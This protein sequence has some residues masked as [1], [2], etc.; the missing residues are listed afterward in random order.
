MEAEAHRM[1]KKF[2]SLGNTSSI[3]TSIPLEWR[4]FFTVLL[5]SPDNCSWATQLL[6]RKLTSYLIICESNCS[7]LVIPPSC[8]DY[9]LVCLT[10]VEG[11]GQ[12]PAVGSSKD[13]PI[14]KRLHKRDAAIVESEVRR[15]PRLQKNAKGFK[16]QSYTNKSCLACGTVPPTLKKETIKKLALDFC[17][18]EESNLDMNL[19]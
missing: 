17:K 4:N 7:E 19:L 15:S 2:F 6:T 12:N 13:V 9:Y 8:P 5:L 3:H 11:E 16:I 1:W 18:M 10:A 14:K